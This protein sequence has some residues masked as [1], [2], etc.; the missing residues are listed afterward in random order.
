MFPL[1]LACATGDGLVVDTPD[2][3]HPVVDTGTEDT[4]PDSATPDSDPDSGEDSGETGTPPIDADA[5]GFADDVDC[6]DADAE[7]HPG[8]EDPCDRVDQ[9]CDG[10]PYD[11]GTCGTATPWGDV[12]DF[13]VSPDFLYMV[14][15]VTGDGIPDA[16]ALGSTDYPRPDGGTSSG[17]ALYAGGAHFPDSPPDAPAD[18]LQVFSNAGCRMD[19]GPDNLGDVDGDGTNDFAIAEQGCDRQVWIHLGP[20]PLDGSSIWMSDADELWTGPTPQENWMSQRAWGG[21]FDGDGRNDYVGSEGDSS[22]GE[23]IAA[24]DVF[25]GG[26]WGE[27]QVRTVTTGSRSAELLD[28][29]EDLDGDGLND[30]HAY[31]TIIGVGPR[32]PIFSGADLAGAD[33]VDI[34][35]LKIAELA[36]EDEDPR[37]EANHLG[38]NRLASVGDWTGDGT[39]ELAMVLQQWAGVGYQTGEAFLFDGTSRGEFYISDAVGSWIGN[40]TSGTGELYPYFQSFDADGDGEQ[41]LL[42]AEEYSYNWYLVPHVLPAPHT[43][44]YGLTFSGEMNVLGDPLDLNGDGYADLSI[45]DHD[46]D[47][48]GVWLGWPIPF[49]DPTAW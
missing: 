21:D 7:V 14:P 39:P 42:F 19:G 30:L 46:N 13:L 45:N 34:D 31:M 4:A 28:M 32:H 36:P 18:A 17:W 26:T 16:F 8:A 44:L 35:D 47:R 22:D 24:F 37:G 38:Y 2:T 41:E 49:D 25:F 3:G 48:G 27:T 40:D 20:F 1:L 10:L 9:D 15:D 23:P 6:D 11:P 43:P 5:D 12:E 33:G 29:L